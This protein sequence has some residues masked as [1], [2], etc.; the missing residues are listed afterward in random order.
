[1]IRNE[2]RE[3]ADPPG[4]RGLRE[5]LDRAAPGGVPALPLQGHALLRQRHDPV[6]EQGVRRL[7]RQTCFPS[8][9]RSRSREI[10][11]DGSPPVPRQGDRLPDLQRAGGHPA[12]TG[13]DEAQLERIRYKAT[14]EFVEQLD[15]WITTRARSGLR[16]LRGIEQQ[17]ASGCRPTGSLSAFAALRRHAGLHAA[18]PRRRRVHHACS[19]SGRRTGVAAGLPPT[20]AA[21]AGRC[22]RCFPT[23]TRSRCIGRS[24]RGA[25]PAGPVPAPR[26]ARR[27]STPTSSR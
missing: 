23:G 15:E 11:F 27:S 3:R 10:D 13:V 17:R 25:G 21:C 26:A 18:G 24:T 1:M 2:T 7:H 5:D 14:P 16:R 8:W 12:R 19:S 9:V 20:R 22:G 4:R 6:A